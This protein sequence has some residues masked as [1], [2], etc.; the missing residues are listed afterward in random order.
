MKFALDKLG[1]KQENI[2]VF[3]WSIGGYSGSYAAMQYADIKGLILDATFDDVVDLATA[4]LP[5]R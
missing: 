3:A 1:F 2:I 5:S 4:K